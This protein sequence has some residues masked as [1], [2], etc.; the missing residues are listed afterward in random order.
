MMHILKR[1][2]E[3]LWDHCALSFA[4]GSKKRVRVCRW[5]CSFVGMNTL[6]RIS[7]DISNPAA[8]LL[9]TLER[10]RKGGYEVNVRV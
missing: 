1:E 7:E 8:G 10:E 9:R 3:R 6:G 5:R 2:M 4:Q